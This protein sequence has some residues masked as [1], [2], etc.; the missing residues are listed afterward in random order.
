MVEEFNVTL[1]RRAVREIWNRGQLEV[2][3]VLF[4]PTYVNHHGLIVDLVR[5]PEAVKASVALYRLAFPKLEVTL[6]DVIANGDRVCLRWIARSQPLGTWPPR[7]T[8]DSGS[9]LTGSMVIQVADSQIVESW[10]DWDQTA[11][12]ARLGSRAGTNG[13]GQEYA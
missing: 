1:V 12:L 13:A 3:D 9:S 2:A 6:H 4:H 7:S 5:G 10:I 8:G 11:A